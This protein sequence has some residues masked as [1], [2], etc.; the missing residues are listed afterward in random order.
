MPY[1]SPLSSP[2][3]SPQRGPGRLAGVVPTMVLSIACASAAQALVINETT[4]DAAEWARTV[5]TQ[6]GPATLTI[7]TQ[8]FGGNPGSNWQH[9]YSVPAGN[10][11]PTRVREAN[12]Y[13]AATYNPAQSGALASLSISFDVQ[14]V[15]TSF[16][17][18]T[19]GFLIPALMQGGHVYRQA[20][21]AIGPLSPNWSPRS[22]TSTA[23]A[24]WTEQDTNA[25]P[26]FSA[27]GGAMQFGYL[28]SLGTVCP[29]TTQGCRATAAGSA[30]D[31]FHVDAIAASVPEPAS[32]L[33]LMA[34]GLFA[35]WRWRWRFGAGSAPENAA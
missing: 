21:G 24:D 28:F 4:M 35:A 10:A 8:D 16:T 27:T 31:N 14:V 34:G 18:G 6:T 29:N 22:F 5:V 30:L 13:T 32:W 33:L 9:Q 1:A 19:A 23:A 25:N 26:D 3:R 20:V 12:I 17:D 15:F 7:F 11:L 2:L